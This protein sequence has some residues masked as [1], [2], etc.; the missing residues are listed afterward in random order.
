VGGRYR[1]CMRSPEGEDHWVWGEYQEIIAVERIAF[2]WNRED[3][4]GNIWNSTIVN[5]TFAAENGGK[6]RFLLHQELFDTVG[7]RDDH[8]IGWSQTF[9]RLASFMEKK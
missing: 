2:T 6:T 7:D 1:F 9:D 5:V 4:D 8:N 3:A